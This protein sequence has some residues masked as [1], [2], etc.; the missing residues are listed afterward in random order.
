MMPGT[1]VDTLT[2]VDVSRA[3]D[4]AV[5]ASGNPLAGATFET[6][7]MTLPDGTMI[8]MYKGRLEDAVKS[9][10]DSDKFKNATE[11][12]L[13]SVWF[14]FSDIDFEHN[15]ATE[16]MPASK[17]PLDA[18]IKTLSGYSNVKIKIGAFGDKTG[19]RAVNYAISEQRALNIE[20]ALEAAGCPRESV[21]VE[22][23][24]K[25]YASIPAT[26][27]NDQRAPDRDIAMRFTR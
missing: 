2:A 19:N 25:E 5:D 16:L 24:G 20:A 17:A 10:L 26:A 27:T 4:S 22:G 15:S 13:R 12:E 18:L 3:T 8:T 9:Y 11:T 1:P 14:E 6:I 23:F 7:P 21:S